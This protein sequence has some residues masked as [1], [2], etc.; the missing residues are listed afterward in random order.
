MNY[1]L[2]DY[3]KFFIYHVINRFGKTIWFSTLFYPC[4]IQYLK[5]NSYSEMLLTIYGNT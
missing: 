5:A 3:F 1:F 4:I 2:F